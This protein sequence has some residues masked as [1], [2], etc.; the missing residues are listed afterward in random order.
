MITRATNAQ[1][2]PGQVVINSGTRRPKEVVQAERAT[3]AA[4]NERIAAAQEDGIEEVARIENEARNK[5]GVRFDQ[6]KNTLTIPR[7]IRARR[8]RAITP[9]DKG[10]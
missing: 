1:K 10:E 3:K 2:H 7:K 4:E 5:K 8:P 6:Q 9:I